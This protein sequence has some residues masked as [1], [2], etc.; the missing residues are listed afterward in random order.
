MR[1][2]LKVPVPEP[3]VTLLPVGD[4][5]VPHTVPR[6]VTVAPPSAETVPPRMA[7]VSVTDVKVGV[8][9]VGGTVGVRVVKEPSAEYEVP[10]ELVAYARK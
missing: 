2:W 4:A 6:L 7:V 8:S 10:A 1:R 9:T 3:S 5:E